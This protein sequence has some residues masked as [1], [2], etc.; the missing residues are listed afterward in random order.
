MQR[1]ARDVG[2]AGEGR[3]GTDERE[4]YGG[5]ADET[6]SV[7]HGR[8]ATMRDSDLLRK[9]PLSGKRVDERG[10]PVERRVVVLEVGN[11]RDAVEQLQPRARDERRGQLVDDLDLLTSSRPSRISVGTAIS[12]RRGHADGISA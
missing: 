3:R 2:G 10:D 11:V 5:Q 12:P 6:S 4:A 1:P 7:T 8:R 9:R